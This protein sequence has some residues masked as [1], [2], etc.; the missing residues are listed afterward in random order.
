M[1]RPTV[2]HIDLAAVRH[3]FRLAQQCAPGCKVVAVIKANGYGH[4][5]V[6]LAQTLAT[7]A[8]AFAV[9]CLEEAIELRMADIRNPIVL[10]EGFFSAAELP[11][12]AHYQ[13]TPVIHNAQQLAQ[14]QTGAIQSPLTVWL[15]MDSGMHRLGFPPAD[16][17]AAYS[18]LSRCNAVQHIVLMSHFACADELDNPF[19]TQQL[20]T[21]TAHCRGLSGAIS[22]ANSA[23]ILA[24]PATHGQWIRPGL[25]LY[26]SSPLDRVTANSQALQAV[27]Q[28]QAQVISIREVAPGEGIGYGGRYRCPRLTRVGVVS[29]GYADGYPRHA[30]DGTPV[31]VKGQRT[32]LIGRVS[33]DMITIDLTH[34]PQV[35]LGDTVE[36]WGKQLNINEVAAACGTLSYELLTRLNQRVPLQYESC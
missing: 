21:F 24:W 35:V 12:I 27:M 33:M 1:F 36:L 34:L 15:K 7:E 8:D 31:V 25:M 5:A 13:L 3:N 18:T 20:A 17:A 4:G 28:L 26:G 10:L 6:P 30:P 32:Q 29:I 19:T 2:A 16:Y 22:L 23:A 9:A 14:L 11:A